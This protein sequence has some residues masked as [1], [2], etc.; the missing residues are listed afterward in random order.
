MSS[1]EAPPRSAVVGAALAPV[2]AA[3]G[4]LA[5]I[6]KEFTIRVARREYCGPLPHPN[7]LGT[8]AMAWA[9]TLGL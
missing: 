9:H 8:H 1:V 7:G 6:A 4:G 2:W 5:A 3:I